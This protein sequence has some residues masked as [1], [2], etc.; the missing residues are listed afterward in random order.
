MSVDGSKIQANASIHKSIRY[1]RAK[2]L[3]QELKVE[4][5]ELLTRAQEADTA[6]EETPDTISPEIA[7][8]SDLRSKL[9][10]ALEELEKRAQQGAQQE[11]DKAQP[12]DT[13]R[14]DGKGQGEGQSTKEAKDQPAPTDQSNLTDPDSRI[15]RKN[16]RSQYILSLQCSGSRGRFRDHARG[17][18]SRDQQW[19]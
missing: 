3:E 9:E 11:E 16:K 13:D 8:L 2:A 6:K 12:S 18:K 15:M 7:K 1:D 17:C 19:E 4:I 5:E 14:E 10:S